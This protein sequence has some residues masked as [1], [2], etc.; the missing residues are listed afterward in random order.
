MIRSWKLLVSYF[1]CRRELQE[2]CYKS[3]QKNLSRAST[4]SLSLGFRCNNTSAESNYQNLILINLCDQRF[5]FLL[6]SFLW[7]FFFLYFLSGFGVISFAF[8]VCFQP[9]PFDWVTFPISEAFRVH[10]APWY[11]PN[12][13]YLPLEAP[14]AA[15]LRDA[16]P[17][18]MSFFLRPF[19]FSPVSI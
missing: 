18:R 15:H 7:W 6:S 8:V 13:V 1:R 4:T 2:L 19:S 5:F 3:K 14:V 9:V 11:N 17:S 16:S 12:R 10:L